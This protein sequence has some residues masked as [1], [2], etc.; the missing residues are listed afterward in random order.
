[1][2]REASPRQ[3]A[4]RHH[5]AVW[6]RVGTWSVA[7]LGRGHGYVSEVEADFESKF[8]A[9]ARAEELGDAY[10]VRG[11]QV[12]NKPLGTVEEHDRVAPYQHVRS[13]P[14]REVPAPVRTAPHVPPPKPLPVPKPVEQKQREELEEYVEHNFGVT[15]MKAVEMWLDDNRPRHGWAFDPDDARMVEQAMREQLQGIA[16]RMRRA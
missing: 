9:I 2:R 6:S 16:R 1:M 10:V 4:I 8:Q 7:V 11:T 5:V 15:P 3:V 13:A 14:S 12:W